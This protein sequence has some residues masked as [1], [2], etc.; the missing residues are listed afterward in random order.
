MVV[1][2]ALAGDETLANIAPH[3][4]GS[5][6]TASAWDPIGLE[7]AMCCPN[8]PLSHYPLQPTHFMPE[9]EAIARTPTS[10]PSAAS[11]AY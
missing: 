10:S 4:P 5:Y 9:A 8:A 7:A 2:P 1:A 11:V 6:P 3:I